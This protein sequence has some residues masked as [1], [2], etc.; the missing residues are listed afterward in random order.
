V[1]ELDDFMPDRHGSLKI[2]HGFMEP[3]G[4]V[5]MTRLPCKVITAAVLPDL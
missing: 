5:T 2:L 4:I 3:D 1:S